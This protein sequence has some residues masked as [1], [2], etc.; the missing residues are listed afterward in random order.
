MNYHDDDQTCHINMGQLA[1][2]CAAFFAE[3][4]SFLESS[5][6]DEPE[7]APEEVDPN[8]CSNVY[9][10]VHGDGQCA[11]LIESAG[12][13]CDTHFC[14]TCMYPG[15]CDQSCG[16]CSAASDGSALPEV[17][18]PEGHQRDCRGL[19]ANSDWIGDSFCDDPYEGHYLNCE[20][21]DFD[22]GDCTGA[23]SEF[24]VDCMNNRAP[25]SWSGDGTCDN[26]IYAHNG[27]W[28][29]LNCAAAEWDGGD[30]AAQALTH[31]ECIQLIRGLDNCEATDENG[32]RCESDECV[33]SIEALASGWDECESLL[34]LEQ[35]ILAQFQAVCGE[36]SP[37]PI[38]EVCGLGVN[39]PDASSP[40]NTEH[41]AETMVPWYDASYS[42]CEAEIRTIGA[43]DEDLTNLQ[44]FYT[45]CVQQGG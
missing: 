26:G 36:C 38:L 9:D 3:C 4:M 37:M 25:V 21:L 8:A 20:E 19:C 45:R 33:Q 27:H 17:A 40:C 28:I 22:G 34:G 18:C 16:T 24:V 2:V 14:S 11:A 1:T 30:C 44:T 42:S 39:F 13:G 35:D 41:C 10:T 29:N 43:T 12:Y 23:S 32:Y 15:F 31:M 5:E 6:E 7:P